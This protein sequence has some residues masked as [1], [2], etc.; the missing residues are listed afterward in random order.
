MDD[1]QV[2]LLDASDRPTFFHSVKEMTP[3]GIDVDKL[4]IDD[5]DSADLLFSDF[6]TLDFTDDEDDLTR[7]L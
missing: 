4:N 7:D 5:S 3:T 6:T 2:T 1:L